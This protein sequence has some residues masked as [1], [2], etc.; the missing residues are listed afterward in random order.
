MTASGIGPNFTD[1]RSWNSS[2]LLAS[3]SATPVKTS[4]VRLLRLKAIALLHFQL[5]AADRFYENISLHLILNVF[6]LFGKKKADGSIWLSRNIKSR[7]A[8][9]SNQESRP[10]F[11][12]VNTN[13]NTT[14][15]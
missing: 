11:P 10:R 8:S 1:V 4:C 12:D 14:S 3:I 7:N 9:K 13:F 5:L 15:N 6:F 2:Q